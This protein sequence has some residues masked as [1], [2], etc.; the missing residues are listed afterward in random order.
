MVAIFSVFAPVSFL[1]V[2]LL[3]ARHLSSIFGPKI[4][5]HCFIVCRYYTNVH[6]NAYLA[7]PR[8][9]RPVDVDDTAVRLS[10]NNPNYS[11]N[12]VLV[13]VINL[14]SLK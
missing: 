4:R 7:L 8:A 6:E 11:S 13:M 12:L 10:T 9:G 2:C 14:C 5:S 3:Q 1:G